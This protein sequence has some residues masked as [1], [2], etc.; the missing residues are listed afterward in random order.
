MLKKVLEVDPDK[1]LTPQEILNEPWMQLTDKQLA[2]IQV[3]NDNERQK[4]V[5]EFLYYNEKKEDNKEDPFLEQEL[6]T[7]MNSEFKNNTTKSIILAPFNSTRSHISD[8]YLINEG[9]LP[10][11]VDKEAL[12]FADKCKEVNR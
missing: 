2:E 12:T 10:L 11:I 3:F 8:D 6:Q 5:D 4:I 7:T 1:R 9:I